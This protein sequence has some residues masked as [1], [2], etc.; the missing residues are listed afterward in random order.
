MAETMF[1]AKL[2]VGLLPL[3]S[4]HSQVRCERVDGSEV[5]V[6]VAAAAVLH[7]HKV[8]LTAQIVLKIQRLV[9]IPYAGS[10]NIE[11][12]LRYAPFAP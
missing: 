3:L 5:F 6:H 10:S 8:L 11:L 1:R 12:S 9:A 7:E 2:V 4:G